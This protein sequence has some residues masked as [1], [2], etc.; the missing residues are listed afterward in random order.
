MGLQ[1]L[2]KI[3]ICSAYDGKDYIEESKKCGV[4]GFIVKPVTMEKLK[5]VLKDVGL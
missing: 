5:N 1:S 3:Y 4:S 2:T